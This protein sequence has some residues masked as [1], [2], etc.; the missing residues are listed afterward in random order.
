MPFATMLIFADVAG[1]TQPA[2]TEIVVMATQQNGEAAGAIRAENQIDAAAI[3]ALGATNLADILAQLASLTGGSQARAGDGPVLLVN[4]RRISTF[5]E[6]RNLPPEAILRVDILPEEAALRLGYPAR[7]KPVNIVLKPF[8][9]SIT[10]EL[11][12]RVTASGLRNDFNTEA[13]LVRIKGDN[14][15]TLDLQVQIGDAIT[16]AKRGVVRPIDGLAASGGGI[17]SA[18]GGGA[19]LPL[20]QAYA[21]VPMGT[22]TLAGF[23]AAPLR[24][25]TG[26]WRSLTPASQQI[27]LNSAFARALTG[28]VALSVN[29]KYDRLA[30]QDLLG[31][32]IAD[33][34]LPVTAPF[35]V[36]LHFRVRLAD[37]PVQT[38]A[39][40][41]DTLHLGAQLTGMGRWRWSI[42]GNADHVALGRDTRGGVDA[43]AWQQAI[44]NGVIADPFA[45]PDAGLLKQGPTRHASS[46]DD[47]MGL[48]GYLS[49]AVFGLP[50]GRA[51]LSLSSKLSR[52]V[53]NSQ[54][55]AGQHHL[56]RTYASGQISLDLPLLSA[57]SVIGAL[58]G[59]LN[60]STDRWS[61]A[62]TVHGYGANLN[63]KPAGGL[64]ILMSAMEDA[65]APTMS[66]L[67]APQNVTPQATLYDF[68]SGRS[69]NTAQTTG[70]NGALVADLRRVLKTQVE[71]K[72]LK[73]LS[74]TGTYTAVRDRNPLIPFAGITPVFETA[75][76]GRVQRDASGAILN[77]DAHP[78]NA[79]L[80]ERQELRVAAVFSRNLGKAQGPIV[81]G[82]GGFGGGHSFGAG[83]SMIQ[84]SLV[85]TMRISD[86]LT[87]TAGGPAYDLVATN[88]LGEAARAPRH[89]IEAQISGTTHG[90]GLRAGGTWV[91][92]GSD[93]AGSAGELRFEDRF[94]FNFR[95]FW[96]PEHSSARLAR[97]PY[98]KGV[99]FLLAVD[100]LFGSWQRVND[101][102]G[103]TPLAY[104]RWILDPMGATVRLSIRKSLD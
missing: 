10:G 1:G 44:G 42:A 85:D 78:F 12:D 33:L 36:P 38:R 84:L 102:A 53:L 18:L 104:Q 93:G 24:D 6:V 32:A 48:D 20:G 60:L 40:I 72:P 80:E 39:T 100:N 83:G 16:E 3:Q 30:Q 59:G 51:N 81:P 89:R 52:E 64:S 75:F 74:L 26:A 54:D 86:R 46:R 31:P 22:R 8:Y 63:W 13:N 57:H 19:L 49:G 77:V 66:Q 56:A 82:K 68:T 79:A 37:Q 43:G 96:F 5:D 87:L 45:T 67:G 34:T 65:M 103:A 61:D 23:A 25:D 99:R 71:W 35:A 28:G 73:G 95:L 92:G 76:A 4:G 101:R 50:A 98:A 11:E 21:G 47:L 58:D 29:A 17:V 70:G 97:L 27:T 14:R 91:S 94:A 88:P 62:G 69:I 9:H 41:T 2:P 15:L 90:W 55:A 7:S